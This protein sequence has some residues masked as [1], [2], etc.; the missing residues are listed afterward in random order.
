MGIFLCFP[1]AS[2]YQRALLKRQINDS[3]RPTKTEDRDKKGFCSNCKKSGHIRENCVQSIAKGNIIAAL[4]EENCCP[5][6]N[7][8]LHIFE[9]PIQGGTQKV[10][11]TRLLNCD[12]FYYAGDEQK[13]ELFLKVKAK[14]NSLCKYCTSWCHKSS[15]CNVKGTCK[16][17]NFAHARGACSLQLL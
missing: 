4:V 11:G 13:R 2:I 17:C 1:K 3:C 6:C 7:D 9:M 8:S 15:E 12:Q 14:V 5:I 16:N 10:T